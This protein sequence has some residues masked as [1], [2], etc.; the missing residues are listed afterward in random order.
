[1]LEAY[2][3]ISYQRHGTELAARLHQGDHV[4][5]AHQQ[6]SDLIR[7]LLTEAAEA[8]DVRDARDAPQAIA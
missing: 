8:G 6:V 4:A 7:Q 5:R 1:V 2:A 3:L